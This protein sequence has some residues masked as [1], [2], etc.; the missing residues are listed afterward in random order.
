M[1]LVKPLFVARIASLTLMMTSMRGILVKLVICVSSGQLKIKIANLIQYAILAYFLPFSNALSLENMIGNLIAP[2]T[3]FCTTLLE[4]PCPEEIYKILCSGFGKIKVFVWHKWI[5]KDCI[6]MVKTIVGINH[7]ISSEGALY[8]IL[9]YDYP[10]P[11]P[12]FW[13]HTGP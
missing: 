10:P 3:N 2:L 9:P 11:P 5:V 4:I 13:T 6:L 1:S 8:V 7:V 12:T